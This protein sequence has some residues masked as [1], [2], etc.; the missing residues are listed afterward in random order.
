MAGDLLFLT[1]ESASWS[2]GPCLLL[3]HFALRLRLVCSLLPPGSFCIL[4]NL[5]ISRAMPGTLRQL[6]QRFNL[7]LQENHE[8]DC[9]ETEETIHC[10]KFCKALR[11]S[12]LFQLVELN[13]N[14]TSA[15]NFNGARNSISFRIW[16]VAERVQ[17]TE[18]KGF[19]GHDMLT[20]CSRH[21]GTSELPNQVWM[22]SV[23]NLRKLCALA[24]G[25]LGTH[26]D[27]VRWMFHAQELFNEKTRAIFAGSYARSQWRRSRPWQPYASCMVNI[28]AAKPITEVKEAAIWCNM[29]QYAY[30]Q[31]F[32]SLQGA[33]CAHSS[34]SFCGH[35]LF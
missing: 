32:L 25:G 16:N 2:P 17:E 3:L 8:T 23:A 31:T 30:F 33:V 15:V 1:I 26:G 27:T 22:P 34:S 24:L 4:P 7:S 5:K 21:Q 12:D 28:L 19:F 11:P 10:A 13:L 9:E 18:Q 20:T 6:E 14:S 35:G 29:M